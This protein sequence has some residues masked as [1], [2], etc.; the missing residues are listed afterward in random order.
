M[1]KSELKQLIREVLK[2]ELAARS[3]ITEGAMNGGQAEGGFRDTAARP[4]GYT[5]KLNHSALA[6]KKTKTV[7]AKDLKPGMITNTGK[8][9]K[10]T[11]IGWVRG[12]QSVEVSYGGIGNQGSSASDVV[13]SDKDYEVLDEA[14]EEE[15]L[16][17]GIFEG[18]FDSKAD[19][20]KKYNQIIANA[21]DKKAPASIAVQISSLAESAIG[22][23]IDSFD[24]TNVSTTKI[25]VKNF[26]TAIESVKVSA[27]KTPYGLLTSVISYVQKYNRNATELDELIEFKRTALHTQSREKD[28]QKAMYY[29]MELVNKQLVARLDRTIARLKK[30]YYI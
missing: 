30:E 16:L 23:T 19:K 10:V 22:E 2:E 6:G 7:K 29:L 14:F 21:F 17:E 20:Q 18:I 15:D 8:I 9:A 11:D 27:K 13:S 1:T 28:G 12:R 24:E 26:I 5:N 4:G 25:A 3:T